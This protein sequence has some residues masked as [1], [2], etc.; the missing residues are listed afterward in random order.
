MY[1]VWQ[2]A[3]LASYQF[4]LHMVCFQFIQFFGGR[5]H[6]IVHVLNFIYQRTVCGSQCSVS[7]HYS[8]EHGIIYFKVIYKE[9]E[10]FHLSTRNL[11]KIPI[12]LCARMYPTTTWHGKQD[13]NLKI[14]I[15]PPCGSVCPQCGSIPQCESFSPLFGSTCTLGNFNHP[16]VDL[17]NLFVNLNCRMFNNMT[18]SITGTTTVELWQLSESHYLWHSFHNTFLFHIS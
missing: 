9:K 7:V 13:D 10:N 2:I 17:I 15:H 6:P 14:S 8:T 16:V 11:I 5:L 1:R 3:N 12:P 4:F 18:L